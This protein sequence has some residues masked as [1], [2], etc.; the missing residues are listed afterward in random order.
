MPSSDADAGDDS[1][2]YGVTAPTPEPRWWR[3]AIMLVGAAAFAAGAAAVDSRP[4][5][6][7]HD[8]AM[9]VILARSLATGHGFR[10]LNL[11]GMPAA[12]HFPPG[13]PAFLALIS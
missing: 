6:I 2:K 12:T 9:Y 5:G 11:P 8:D 10:F 7:V 13:Y 1:S 4:V 3:L